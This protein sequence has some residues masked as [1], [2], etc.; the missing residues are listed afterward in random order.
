M[1][2]IGLKELNFRFDGDGCKVIY[3]GK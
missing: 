1:E 2:K 3:E